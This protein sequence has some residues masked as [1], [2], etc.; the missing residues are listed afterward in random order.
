[1]AMPVVPIGRDALSGDVVPW[2]AVQFIG[3]G[4]SLVR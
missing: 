3:K 1:L 4:S 2:K